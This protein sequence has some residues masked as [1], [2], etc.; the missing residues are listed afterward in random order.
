VPRARSESARQSSGNSQAVPQAAAP[1]PLPPLSQA[2]P[3]TLPRDASDD[4]F[5]EPSGP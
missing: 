2:R 1:N 5:A 3:A 4:P